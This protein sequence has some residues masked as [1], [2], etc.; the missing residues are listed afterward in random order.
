MGWSLK[1][2]VLINYSHVAE[3]K[4]I[5]NDEL[6]MVID[7]FKTDTNN[8]LQLIKS[9]IEIKDWNKIKQDTH[10]LKGAAANLGFQ[11]FSD[12]CHQIEM[13]VETQDIALISVLVK[14]LQSVLLISEKRVDEFLRL[15]SI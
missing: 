3:M 2:D 12:I 1:M 14:E 8:K 4:S 5:L 15:G 7:V 11:T 6:F 13:A 9:A 10:S